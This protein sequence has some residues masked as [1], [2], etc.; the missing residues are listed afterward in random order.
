[1]TDINKL[2]KNE[3]SEIETKTAVGYG[4]V[5]TD[6]ESQKESIDNQDIFYKDFSKRN[7]MKYLKTYFDKGISGKQAY[8]RESFQNLIL[9][10]KLGVFQTVL[11]K[12]ISRFARNTLDLL[13][14]TRELKKYGVEVRFITNNQT[15]MDGEFLITIFGAI[16]QE[17]SANMSK[18]IKFSKS[19]TA[20]KGRVPNIVFGYDKMI[21]E[22]YTLHVNEEEAKIVREI[23]DMYVNQEH[24]CRKIAN[25]LTQRGIKTKRDHV[26]FE[27]VGIG[28][29]LQNQLYTGRVTNGKSEV[30]D[31]LTGE[32]KKMDKD[33]WIVFERPELRIIDDD[34]FNKAQQILASRQNE[35]KCNVQRNRTTHLLST[36]IRCK[37][38]G[39]SFKRTQRTYTVGGKTHIK[40][41]CSFRN[42]RGAKNCPN[43]VVIDEN[44]LIEKIKGYF[45]S[46][47]ENEEQ[48]KQAVTKEYLRI[49][50]SQGHTEKLDVK[51][52][53]KEIRTLKIQRQK[54]M[55]MYIKEILDADDL[56]QQIDPIKEKI[57]RLE[58]EKKAIEKGLSER[59]ELESKLAQNIDTMKDILNLKVLKNLQLKSILEN[60]ECDQYG[61]VDIRIKLLT[62]FGFILDQNVQIEDI[63]T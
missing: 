29:M 21:G 30:S 12:D 36:L 35:F 26:D 5:S 57:I 10:A 16:A 54:Y 7:H 52:V 23:F 49:R 9:D 34:I 46:I 18:R 28:R 20:K 24:G 48:F 51:A 56:K 32:R 61:N 62:D 1:M 38:C 33:D 22:R 31:F 58:A 55:E 15:T 42:G 11:V 37:C 3:L 8:N 27:N 43:A 45:Q 4:R 2:S 13:T 40:W 39:Y 41:V 47:I 17:E 59:K 14:F 44:N 25:I 19:I 63:S 60:I 6:K 50:K 53:D